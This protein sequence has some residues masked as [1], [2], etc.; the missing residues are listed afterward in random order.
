MKAATDLDIN[1][2]VRRILVKHWIDLGRMSVR[3]TS[4]VVYLYG[5]LQRLPGAAGEL[6]PRLI[7]TMFYEIKRIKAVRRVN[8]H[9][10]NWTSADGVWRQVESA[11]AD[12]D[13][14]PHAN[15]TF[16]Q[17]AKPSSD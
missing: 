5:R 11:K 3:T 8:P 4:G 6:T 12:D 14:K 10:D 15:R 7:E 2:S 9:F 1:R 17:V 16:R 13:G